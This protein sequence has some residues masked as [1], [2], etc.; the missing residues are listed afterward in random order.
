ME[1]VTFKI[2]G[3]HCASCSA[4]TTRELE[5]LDFVKSASVN[6]ATSEATVEFESS[7]GSIKDLFEAVKK[8]GFEPGAS[9]D[10]GKKKVN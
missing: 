2:D 4:L 9:E 3:M 1:K 10:E 7:R 8:A 6:F 5:S